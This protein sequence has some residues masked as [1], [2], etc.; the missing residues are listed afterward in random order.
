MFC[1]MQLDADEQKA[2]LE[3]CTR[4]MKSF[5]YGLKLGRK[6]IYLL[7][8]LKRFAVINRIKPKKRRIFKEYDCVVS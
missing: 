6:D 7:L 1:L 5:K 8:Y 4:N 3:L 2:K